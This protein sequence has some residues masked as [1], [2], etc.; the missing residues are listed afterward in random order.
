MPL[1]PPPS[2]SLYLSMS[3]SGIPLVHTSITLGPAA[4][5]CHDRTAG[6]R[7]TQEERET[8][9]CRQ[10]LN[11]LGLR[12]A[13]PAAPSFE[14]LVDGDLGPVRSIL[15]LHSVR[16]LYQLASLPRPRPL[17]VSPPEASRSGVA[18]LPLRCCSSLAW[19]RSVCM[20][21]QCLDCLPAS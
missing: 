9:C 8:R 17:Y 11:R 6:R 7:V 18:R 5:L 14:S 10:R 20:V 2:C 16:H 1:E 4:S 21:W 3:R 19:H 15:S 13:G 12:N